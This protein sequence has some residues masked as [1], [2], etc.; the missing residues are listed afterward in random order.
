MWNKLIV[1]YCYSA[2]DNSY[3]DTSILT[4]LINIFR[5]SEEKVEESSEV[6]Q[7]PGIKQKCVW[8]NTLAS[9]GSCPQKWPSLDWCGAKHTISQPW[10]IVWPTITNVQIFKYKIKNK[11]CY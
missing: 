3:Y 9:K 4:L 11:L 10:S 1:L 7:T 5:Q 8:K 2:T 6:T